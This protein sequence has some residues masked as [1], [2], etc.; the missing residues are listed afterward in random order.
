MHV[1]V[2]GAQKLEARREHLGVRVMEMV[3]DL[4]PRWVGWVWA[5]G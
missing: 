3:V 5:A 4:L 1:E 2:Q